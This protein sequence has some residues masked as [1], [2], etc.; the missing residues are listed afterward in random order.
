MKKSNVINIIAF[1]TII[2]LIGVIIKQGQDIKEIKKQFG[3]EDKQ[4]DTVEKEISTEEFR[5][6]IK[7]INITTENWKDY[8]ELEEETQEEKNAFGDIISS[9][10]LITFK[11]NDN[12]YENADTTDIALEIEIPEEKALDYKQ[13]KTTIQLFAG[14]NE[15]SITTQGLIKDNENI[16]INDIKCTR[17]VGTIY[18]L[19]NIPDEYWN[20]ENG[21]TVGGKT[22]EYINV[23]GTKYYKYN[24][25]YVY[26]KDFV[27]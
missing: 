10:R 12:Y 14:R 13:N 21:M 9:Q 4:T 22:E 17:A 3:I 24:S 16:T 19:D 15:I 1:I 8:F 11:L 20:I 27:E 6:Y 23:D 2:F 18:Y 5:K 7:Q 25:N 26:L